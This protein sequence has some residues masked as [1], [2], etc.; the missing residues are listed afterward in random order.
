MKIARVSDGMIQ[1]KDQQL[2]NL[3]LTA[4]LQQFKQNPALR[5]AIAGGR[6][7]SRPSAG[8]GQILGFRRRTMD[9]L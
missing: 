7:R 9:Q 8:P 5:P 6:H 3:A 2:P 4:A 1:N